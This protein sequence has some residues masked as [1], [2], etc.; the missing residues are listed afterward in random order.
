M[1][2]ISISEL[3]KELKET[4]YQ[5]SDIKL[6]ENHGMRRLYLTT[7]T[8]SGYVSDKTFLT[9][10]SESKII[11]ISKDRTWKATN[12]LFEKYNGYKVII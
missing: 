12:E 1:K 2:E 10:D 6:W 7:Y 9:L 5:K 11:S 8:G 3:E 4:W